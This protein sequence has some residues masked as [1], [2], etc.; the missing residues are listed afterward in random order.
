MKLLLS[1]FLSLAPDNP[2]RGEQ[3]GLFPHPR[4]CHWYYNCSST[5]QADLSGDQSST[6]R[7]IDDP[8][9]LHSGLTSARYQQ[10]LA[11]SRA[12]G[13]DFILMDPTRVGQEGPLVW[14]CRYPQLFD[15]V[16]GRCRE[17]I[18]VKCLSRFEPYD[19]CKYCRKISLQYLFN[20]DLYWCY[21]F[22]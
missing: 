15:Q 8:A 5:S 14:E 21:R 3:E 7:Y 9:S 11:R 17:F 12:G 6:D 22:G 18:N 19:Q 1:F 20:P 10:T 13:E 16:T 2:C 4:N